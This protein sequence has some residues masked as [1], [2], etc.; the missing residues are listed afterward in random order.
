MLEWPF[1]FL[2]GVLGSAH[3]VG[4]CGGFAVTVGAG[5]PTFGSLLNRQLVYTSGRIFTYAFLG[6]VGGFAGQSLAQY[7]GAFITSQ[8][9]FSILAGL[10]MVFVG[11][12]SIGW[13][14]RRRKGLGVVAR[15]WSTLFSQ[16]LNAK[17]RWGR[18]LAGVANGFLPCGLVYTFLALAVASGQMVNGMLLMAAFGA[19]TAP[20]MILIGC[21]SSSLSRATRAR[22]LTLAA[23]AMIA[24]GGMSIYRAIPHEKSCCSPEAECCAGG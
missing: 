24:M 6:A 23:V 17:G 4:M 20:A 19:G 2:A 18:F 22:V 15:I 7:N 9:V 11:L 13:I 10:I 1:L 5:A 14:P 12:S 8:R 16:F 3:C 21:G